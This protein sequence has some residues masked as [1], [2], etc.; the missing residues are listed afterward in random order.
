MSE[1]S[2]VSEVEGLYYYER[3]LGDYAKETRHLSLLEHGVYTILLDY[4]FATCQS[5]PQ[6]QIYRYACARTRAEKRAVDAV[7]A[8]FFFLHA[9]M[10]VCK[11]VQRYLKAKDKRAQTSKE[12]GKLGGRPPKK[13]DETDKPNDNNR[14]ENEKPNQNLTENLTETYQEPNPNL[15]KPVPIAINPIA[16]NPIANSPLPSN[17]IDNKS[18][19]IALPAGS[20]KKTGAAREYRAEFTLPEWD[21]ASNSTAT[22]DAAT[23][24]AQASTAQNPS[25]KANA[26]TAPHLEDPAFDLKTHPP[27][28]ATGLAEPLADPDSP[29]PPLEAPSA[30]ANGV[31][32]GIIHVD[33]RSA[34]ND[35]TQTVSAKPA[36]NVVQA[37]AVDERAASTGKR[38]KKELTQE[39]KNLNA[40]I[41]Q[42]YRAAYVERYGVDPLRDKKVNGQINN[43][44]ERLGHEAPDVAAYY[45][46]INDQWLIKTGHP[47]GQLLQG[48]EGYRMQWATGRKITST[49]AR[50]EERQQATVDMVK[51]ALNPNPSAPTTEWFNPF[52][53]L[54]AADRA[55][56]QA[57]QQA[58]LGVQPT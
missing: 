37:E 52:A 8:E 41:W 47:I 53:E 17:P 44:R 32:K 1:V 40:T 25:A 7:L 51:A 13:S 23:D 36:P 49:K 2:E 12:N 34:K 39:Q 14:L 31:D 46:E 48:C 35:A 28:P 26:E 5:I 20:A 29:L 18:K 19:S 42:R 33:Y 9:G 57:Q 11:L 30:P 24:S 55:R 58:R 50:E 21:K 27:G 43:L 3:H 16:I 15:K 38:G 56:F 54:Q 4:C 6:T 22:K 45:L 10:Y